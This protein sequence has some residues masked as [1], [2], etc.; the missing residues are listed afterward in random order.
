MALNSPD[1]DLSLH[2]FPENRNLLLVGRLKIDLE[3]QTGL[4]IKNHRFLSWQMLFYMLYQ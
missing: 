4:E 2:C 3:S 1:R